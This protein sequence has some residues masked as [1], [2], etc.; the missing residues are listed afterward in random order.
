MRF[1][2]LNF[3]LLIVAVAA[4]IAW[5]VDKDRFEQAL[6]NYDEYPPTPHSHWDE[7]ADEGIVDI[8]SIGDIS[9]VYCYSDITQNEQ[10]VDFDESF[11]TEIKRFGLPSAAEQCGR[12]NDAIF[13]LIN[14]SLGKDHQLHLEKAVVDRSHGSM[15]WKITWNLFPTKSFFAGIPYQY[16][17]CVRADG[18]SVPPRI[19]LRDYYGSR[20]DDQNDLL[21]SVLPITSLPAKTDQLIDENKLIET[22]RAHLFDSLQKLNVNTQFR[23]E[24]ITRQTFSP[25]LKIQSHE[26]DNE[27]EV[28]AVEFVDSLIPKTVQNTNSATRITVWVKSDLSTSTISEHDWELEK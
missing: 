19:Y 9:F 13:A 1:S 4:I 24:K 18:S 17:G 16:V 26:S 15:F 14:E 27:L 20:Y 10:G 2:I 7:I 28:W 8:V 25:D 5:R 3:F 23:F 11:D 6:A 12:P 22:A 21:F